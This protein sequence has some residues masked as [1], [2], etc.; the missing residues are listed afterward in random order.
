[1]TLHFESG[2][3]S[4]VFF[5]AIRRGCSHWTSRVRSQAHSTCQDVHGKIV[6][7]THIDIQIDE[8][9]QVGVPESAFNFWAAYVRLELLR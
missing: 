8:I 7:L 9:T 5:V 2:V 4:D 6:R 3:D 1:M